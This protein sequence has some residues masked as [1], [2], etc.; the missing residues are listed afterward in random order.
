MRGVGE[1]GEA[2]GLE[3]ELCVDELLEGLVRG[4]GGGEEGGGG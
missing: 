1:A 3:G 2:G 4:L